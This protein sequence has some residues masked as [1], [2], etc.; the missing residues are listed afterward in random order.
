MLREAAVIEL[1][2]WCVMARSEPTGEA[3]KVLAAVLETRRFSKEATEPEALQI[4]SS[5]LSRPKGEKE[6]S[7]GFRLRE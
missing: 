3:M 1:V 7:Y 4:T 5:R 6:Y 2:V